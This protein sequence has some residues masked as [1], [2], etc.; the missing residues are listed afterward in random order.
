[1]TQPGSSALPSLFWHAR[2]PQAV[3]Q[4]L[5]SGFVRADETAAYEADRVVAGLSILLLHEGS[6]FQSFYTA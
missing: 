2:L 1:M 5:Q 6:C 4:A 3:E